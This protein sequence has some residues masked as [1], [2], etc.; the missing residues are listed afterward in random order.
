L[1]FPVFSTLFH[2]VATIENATDNL[3]YLE[4]DHLKGELTS[5]TVRGGAVTMAA[6]AV[7]E[8]IRL[9]AMAILARLLFPSDYGLVA[10]VTVVTGFI[11]LFKDLGLSMA[12]VQREKITQEQI[13]ALFWVNVAV[14]LALVLITAGVAPAI[15]WFYKEPRLLWIAIALAPGFLFTGFAVQH[16]ALLRRQMRFTTLALLDIVALLGSSGIA[17][18]MA[19]LGCGYWALVGRFLASALIRAISLWLA[20]RWRPGK[21]IRGSGIRSMLAF[22]GNLTGFDAVNYFARNLDKVLLGRAWGDE[23]VGLYSKAYG[24]LLFPLRAV[25]VPVTSVAIPALSRLRSDPPKYIHVYK[26]FLSFITFVTMPIVVLCFLYSDILIVLALGDRWLAAA[27]I[28][29]VLA[30]AGFVATFNI[31]TDWVYISFGQTDRMLRAGIATSLVTVLSFFIGVRWG[32]LGI[33]YAYVIASIAVRYPAIVYCYQRT[34]IAM[35]DLLEAIWRP[36]VSSLLAGGVLWLPLMLTRNLMS[37]RWIT[38]LSGF[39]LFAMLYLLLTRISPGGKA[40]FK[41]AFALSKG[42]FRQGKSA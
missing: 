29:R 13:S 16:R 41:S 25:N 30:V 31:A 35:T 36:A 23:Q 21:L 28:F 27:Q 20:C 14:S 5:R 18:G 6:Q 22:G 26:R 17:I 37:D 32:A 40:F 34:P 10:M 39:A 19:L 24:L 38:L 12:T 8:A 7:R 2:E 42:L 9:G 15:A 3:Q 11:G 4:I 33:A 1:C